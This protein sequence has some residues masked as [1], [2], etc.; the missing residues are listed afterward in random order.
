MFGLQGILVT[1][2]TVLTLSSGLLHDCGD[3]R[4]LY[5]HAVHL[6]RS[7]RVAE[8]VLAVFTPNR[9]FSLQHL[10]C[11]PPVSVPSDLRV[12]PFHVTFPGTKYCASG[13]GRTN[14]NIVRSRSEAVY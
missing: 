7:F 3:R 2:K 10:E 9:P 14:R 13:T 5:E 4:P 11:C 8:P 6:R 12:R 1:V